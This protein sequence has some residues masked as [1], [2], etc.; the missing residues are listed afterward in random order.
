MKVFLVGGAVR[1][2]LL[3]L[4]IKDRDWVVV[5]ATEAQMKSHGY[6]AIGR[7]FPVF[8]HPDTREEY[9]LARTERKSG[10][11]YTGFEFHAD[12][13]VSLQEDLARRDLTINAIA[14]DQDGTLTDPYGGIQDLQAKLLRH[15]SPAFSEDPLRVLRV[16]RFAARYHHLGFRIADATLTLMQSM[17]SS[18]ELKHLI[19]ER[20]W[21]ET[22]HALAEL[23]PEIY[24]TTLEQCGALKIVLPEIA[25][26]IFTLKQLPL[27]ILQQAQHQNH[28][29]TERFA[30]ISLQT[31]SATPQ[32]IETIEKLAQRLRLP[33]DFRELALLIN[34]HLQDYQKRPLS[35]CGVWQLIEKLDGLRRPERFEHFF[36]CA[37]LISTE[38][39]QP[40][41][42]TNT[43]M[44]LL[45]H[46]RRI[47][48]ADLLAQGLKGKAIGDE[49]RK[50]RIKITEQWLP[51]LETTPSVGN[52]HD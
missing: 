20:V 44:Q 3:H 47:D 31:V 35:P 29:L 45:N 24:F 43:I 4:P 27:K 13:E 46:A 18:G 49:L 5:G 21:Q 50:Q 11:G 37:K 16:A 1:D 38:V 51:K 7:D 30:C 28:S 17:S 12:P 22:V 10:H 9:A 40:T 41:L 52:S 34:R 15:V 2:E 39:Q 48:S 42:E 32:A 19:E 23:H 6:K 14:R 36:R 33:Q 8:L 25:Q 26:G